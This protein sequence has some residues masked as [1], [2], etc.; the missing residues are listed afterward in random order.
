MIVTIALAYVL[1][2][3][4]ITATYAYRRFLATPSPVGTTHF[5]K[6][7]LFVPVRGMDPEFDR[8]LES[9]FALDYPDYEVVFAV[10]DSDDCAWGALRRACARRPGRGRIVV[11]GF[12]D[13]CSEKIHNLLACYRASSPDSEVFVVLDADIQAHP[14]L[15]RR[16]VVPLG[17]HGVGAV[18]GYRWLVTDRPTLARTVATMT[19]AA[20][21][22]SF[23][24]SNNVWGGTMAIRRDTFE[25][26]RVPAI[27][28]KTLSDDLTLRRLLLRN[29]MRVVSIS[30]GLAVS[31][32]DYTWRTYW[33]FLVRQL[34][35]ARVYTPALWW[36]VVAFYALTIPV[37][38]YAAV[39]SLLWLC[40]LSQATLPLVALPLLALFM[41]Q[42]WLVVDGAQRAIRRRGEAIRELGARQAPAYL[43]ALAV[44]LLQLAASTRRRWI[45]WRGVLY[46][47]HSHDH[48]EVVRP[49]DADMQLGEVASRSASSAG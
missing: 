15:L 49:H 5:P 25:R 4:L 48:T 21:A 46:R 33:E 12:S 39:G 28:S 8:H 45:V 38:F 13:S 41:F 43:L 35:I 14:L 32:Q 40:G 18:T 17:D 47:M 34:I 36:Q 22:V 3:G 30:D 16:L 42:G 24:L 37:T 19:N 10:A 2:L 6:L 44:G 31:H 9:F 27:W 20:G 1:M 29:G 11:A 26:L 7:S 23:W